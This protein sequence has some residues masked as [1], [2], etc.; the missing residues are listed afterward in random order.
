MELLETHRRLRAMHDL[1]IPRRPPK[2]AALLIMVFL[3]AACSRSAASAGAGGSATAGTSSPTP[4]ASSGAG[5]V[6]T[7]EG[8]FAT[9]K[10][11]SPWFDGVGPKNASIVGQAAWWQAKPA[12]DG[13]W[14]LTVSVGWGDCP[15]GCINH[16]EWSWLVAPD[17]SLTFQG[18]NGPALPAAQQA[19]LA[20]AARTSGI[21]GTV[22]AGPTCPVER[23][24]ESACGDRSVAGAV[25]IVRNGAGAEVARFTTDGSGLF[26]MDVPAGA[27]TLEPQPA[28][29]L[30]GKPSAQQVTVTDGK[31]TLVTL[32]YDTGIR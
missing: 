20:A 24:G 18:Q 10:A 5:R 30:M 3:L 19:S 29:A 8:A 9:V 4:V 17:G 28:A 12:A 26:R 7:A 31:L 13:E 27:Y 25:L 32:A 16:H 22:Q 21:G 11:R 15:S 6:A 23:P 2:L 1:P 14:V